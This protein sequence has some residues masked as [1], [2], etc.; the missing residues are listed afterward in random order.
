MF[1]S[2]NNENPQGWKVDFH[3]FVI[4]TVYFMYFTTKCVFIKK[5]IYI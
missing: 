4:Y 1:S 3:I 2:V 5:K